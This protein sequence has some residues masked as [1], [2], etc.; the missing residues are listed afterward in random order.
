VTRRREPVA[1]VPPEVVTR[2]RGR[3]IT[4]VVR[5]RS[6]PTRGASIGR[7]LVLEQVGEGG[8]ATVH[9]A[10]DPELD[11]RVALKLLRDDGSD[12]EAG[13]Q[14]IVREAR[15]LAKLSHPHVVPVYDVGEHEDGVY[16]AMELVD[17]Q[18]LRTWM[19]QPRGW[20][21]VLRVLLPAGRGL[22]AAHAAGVVHRDFKPGNVMLGADGRVRV[23]DFGLARAG[24][25]MGARTAPTSLSMVV[26]HGEILGTPAYMAP[27]QHDGRALDAR[28]DQFAF[29][30]T[31][32]E[33]IYGVRPFAGDTP[34]L[35]RGAIA[36]GEIRRPAVRV[37]GRLAR[38]IDRGLAEDPQ[39]RHLSMTVL[40]EQLERVLRRRGR[41]VRLGVLG[42][43]LLGSSAVTWAVVGREP[44]AV[45]DEVQ[46]L[47]GQAR[48]AAAKVLFVYPPP[49]DPAQ[50][51]A[52]TRVL[53]LEALTAAGASE[54]AA[55]LREEFA[56]T[57]RRVGDEYWEREGGV[58]FAMDYYAQALVFVPDDAHA[59]ER[60]TLTP[61]ELASLRDKAER[62]GFSAAELD[63]GALLAALALP[64]ESAR[65]EAV[66]RQ[67]ARRPGARALSTDLRLEA[68]M[69]GAAEGEG[70]RDGA[71]GRPV[72]VAKAEGEAEAGTP[73]AG[74][75][76][77]EVGT[78]AVGAAGGEAVEGERPR[79][80]KDPA[81]A[82]ALVQAAAAAMKR[83]D[84]AEA[85]RLLH[86]AI[87]AD[88]RNAQAPAELSDLCFDR[89]RYDE[90]ARWARRAVSLAP[91]VAANHMRLGDALFKVLR[92]AEARQAYT[93]A[94]QRGAAGAAGRLKQIDDK[95]GAK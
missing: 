50:P 57:L 82:R 45:V 95:L 7:Y 17:G 27:E 52:F 60:T 59:R 38:V 58:G 41:V 63:A 54:T 44:A 48:D 53:Q 65:R 92:Y 70:A 10:Y 29:C 93:A 55:Q 22:E 39:A 88:P 80:R 89:G 67:R 11:R 4:P 33:A 91:R 74:V 21:E 15:A 56:A 19:G 81:A 23:V 62:Q 24:E 8:M 79:V 83:R 75:G 66:A 84:H 43:A 12:P 35:L 26:T 78:P 76:E 46:T 51:T 61:G 86:R 36:R 2:P 37:P 69:A 1:V 30:V 87:E 68:L 13:A 77:G 71:A 64:E 34:E 47:A 20:R 32:H 16:M 9:V 28:A 42:V 72:V 90:A 6:G 18:T 73:A 5:P 94:Q 14:R 31:L 49:D 85:E 40:R 3:A 25:G